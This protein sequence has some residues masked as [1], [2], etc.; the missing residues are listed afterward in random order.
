MYEKYNNQY[1][2]LHHS[3]SLLNSQEI[4]E[5]L[6]LEQLK[7]LWDISPN[8]DIIKKLETFTVLSKNLSTAETTIFVDSILDHNSECGQ[9]ITDKLYLD[10][11]NLSVDMLH[12]LS[13]AKM[14]K[15]CTLFK[16][17]NLNMTTFSYY[18]NQN[19][20]RSASC[21]NTSAKVLANLVD[22]EDRSNVV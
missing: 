18:T 14:K 8:D 11:D 21:L 22:D 17:S 6:S 1:L 12:L 4:E 3:E 9:K 7:T 10:D 13:P 15:R 19:I 16:V 5:S 20:N 2:M